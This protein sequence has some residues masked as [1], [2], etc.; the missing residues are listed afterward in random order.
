MKLVTK[1]CKQQ[2]SSG[3]RHLS[4]A[5]S[6][7]VCDGV[8]A[9]GEVWRRMKGGGWAGVELLHLRQ[10]QMARH[11]PPVRSDDPLKTRS[12]SQRLGLNSKLHSENDGLCRS[13][14]VCQRDELT[15][16]TTVRTENL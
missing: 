6:G 16:A 5:W 1:T 3:W 9:D 10:D 2:Q 8:D 14:S 11:L 12:Y 7:E 4:P 15:A 13:A